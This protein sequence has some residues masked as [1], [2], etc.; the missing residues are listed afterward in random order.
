MIAAP[1]PFKRFFRMV[2]N[3]PQDVEA[4]VSA[5]VHELLDFANTAYYPK[6]LAYLD[7]EA[8]KP[9]KVGDHMDMIQSAVR[10]NTLRDIHST[11]VRWVMHA[12]S[13]VQQ[14]EE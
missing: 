9:L 12:R 14:E 3:Q 11:L 6:F 8:A 2:R 13:A 4:T 7:R 10:S 1:D 5:E